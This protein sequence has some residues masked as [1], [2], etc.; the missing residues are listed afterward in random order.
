MRVRIA[1]AGLVAAG[2]LLGWAQQR[3]SGSATPTQSNTD[4]S[5]QA[6]LVDYLSDLATDR[7]DGIIRMIGNVVFHHNGAI[8]QCD[9]AFKY[10]EYRMDFFGKVVVWQDSA[11]IYGDRV[12]YDGRTSVANVYAPIVKMMRGD[13]TLYTY[14]LT[15]NTKTEIGVFW[16]GGVVTQKENLMESE[17]GEY[18]SGTNVIKFLDSVCLRNNRYKIRTDSLM[19]L[20][21]AEQATFLSRTYI[22]DSERDFL[23][24]DWGD[25]YAKDSTYVFTRAPYAL[26]PERE[27]WADTMRYN[28]GRKQAYLFSNAQIT[29]TINTSIFFGDWVFYDDSLGHAVLTRTPSVRGWQAPAK[30][31]VQRYDSMGRPVVRQA[32]TTYMRGD[33]I[34]LST[35]APG[36]SKEGVTRMMIHRDTTLRVDTLGVDLSRAKLFKRIDTVGFVRIDPRNPDERIE[37]KKVVYTIDTAR[38]RK[39]EELVLRP[40]ARDSVAQ[41]LMVRDSIATDSITIDSLPLQFDTVRTGKMVWVHD[42]LSIKE[43]SVPDTINKERI[44]RSFRRVKIWN[45]GYQSVC[46]S[47]VS[48]TVDSMGTMYIDPILWNETNQI[49]ATEMSLYTANEALD[50]GD[51]TGDP[52]IAQQALKGDTTHFNQASGK[53]LRTFFTDNEL[54]NALMTGNVLNLYYK[55][56]GGVLETLA[57]ITCAELNI[58]FEQREPIRMI[59][60]GS[61]QGVIYPI[62]DIPATQPLFL[63]GFTWQDSL[64]PKSAIEVCRRVERPSMRA[65]VAGYHKPSFAISIE[66]E[67]RKEEL[68]TAGLWF[69]RT[70]QPTVTPDYFLTNNPYL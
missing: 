29:D 26:T 18:N 53:R 43:T 41:N 2:L 48:Y 49:T 24:A 56:E 55:D 33:S 1:I 57:S 10:D 63:E 4:T 17:R 11:F 34:L 60:S 51:F 35:Y 66:M 16:G 7:G 15:F 3:P 23:R 45:K 36:T 50:W 28:T 21:D 69:D 59:W 47:L 61:G 31:S 25:Y 30:D 12:E 44:I 67:R 65:E 8:I 20:M 40:L 58:L 14:N 54:D 22:W 32:D 27:M 68:K 5:Q 62:E 19:Y 52:F 70:D 6:V 42:A 9:S 39:A 38:Y 46:D 37:E 13:V 64:R